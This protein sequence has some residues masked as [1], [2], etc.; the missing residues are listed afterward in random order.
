MSDDSIEDKLTK[1][2][3]QLIKETETDPNLKSEVFSTL[4]TIES[5]AQVVDLFTG[6]MVETDVSFLD[7]IF[8]NPEK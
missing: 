5:I 1:R 8:L 2:F 4:A 3:D 7:G 6:K